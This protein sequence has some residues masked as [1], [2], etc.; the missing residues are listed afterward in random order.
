MLGLTNCFFPV[1]SLGV[2][3]MVRPPIPSYFF[4]KSQSKGFSVREKASV[5]SVGRA[6]PTPPDTLVQI[7]MLG[8]KL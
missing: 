3:L 1:C 2:L 4:E 8:A 7:A 5:G 6:Y